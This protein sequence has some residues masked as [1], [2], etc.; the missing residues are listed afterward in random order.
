LHYTRYWTAV[1][2]HA[3]LASH[4]GWTAVSVKSAGVV[5]V[6]A[7]FSLAR[8]FGLADACG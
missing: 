6:A 3:C 5:R 7:R 4:D 2:G 8:A 1:Q